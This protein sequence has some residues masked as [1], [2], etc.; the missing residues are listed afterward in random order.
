MEK[1]SCEPSNII[2]R[3][4]IENRSRRQGTSQR[5]KSRSRVPE[6]HC[7]A[8]IRTGNEV[9]PSPKRLHIYRNGRSTLFDRGLVAWNTTTPQGKTL[10][11]LKLVFLWILIAMFPPKA[12]RARF[13]FR[14]FYCS[15]CLIS[16]VFL[17]LAPMGPLSRTLFPP[18]P[19]Q[20]EFHLRCCRWF[21]FTIAVFV[22]LLLDMLRTAVGPV[23]FGPTGPLIFSLLSLY[24]LTHPFSPYSP[25]IMKSCV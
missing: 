21:H 2:R 22:F 5:S 7:T 11:V 13:R 3:G 4:R 6:E 17:L 18:P 8:T 19:P 25:Q 24:P 14:A 9:N 23:C 16:M 20:K 15:N 1:R 12:T 10:G